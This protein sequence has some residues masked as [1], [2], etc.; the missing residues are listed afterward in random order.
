ML[1]AQLEGR[2]ET[3]EVQAGRAG[4]G[5]GGCNV[6]PGKFSFLQ[7]GC[8]THQI[9]PIRYILL[10][11]STFPV[12]GVAVLGGDK[13]SG[14]GGLANITLGASILSVELE[15]WISQAMLANVWPTFNV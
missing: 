9:I 4:E 6:L 5:R 14:E 3:K 12:R 13:K 7:M 1:E 8:K 15:P 2:V 10:L 11:L